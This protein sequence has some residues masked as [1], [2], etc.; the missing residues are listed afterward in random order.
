MV[1]LEQTR[2][3]SCMYVVLYPL[4]YP[5]SRSKYFVSTLFAKTNKLDI[6]VHWYRTVREAATSW[7]ACLSPDEVQVW[8]HDERRGMSSLSGHH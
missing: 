2:I 8:E 7:P 5:M 4:Q 3:F 1:T 6:V